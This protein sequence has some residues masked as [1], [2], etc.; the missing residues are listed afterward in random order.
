MRNLIQGKFALRVKKAL[1]DRHESAGAFALRI[2]YRRNTVSLA[3][4]ST[5]KLPGCR[6]AILEGLK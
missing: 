6:R 3:L 5:R 2:G 1:L 4:H